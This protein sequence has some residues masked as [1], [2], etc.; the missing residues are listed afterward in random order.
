MIIIRE[1]ETTEHVINPLAI[2]DEKIVMEMIKTRHTGYFF[3]G[4]F[5]LEIHDTGYTIGETLMNNCDT[6]GSA[7]VSVRFRATSMKFIP[8]EIIPCVRI[9]SIKHGFLIANALDNL[10][11]IIITPDDFT[12]SLKEGQF[13]S[14]RIRKAEETYHAK[15]ITLYCQFY[16]P[17]VDRIS[18]FRVLD[19]NVRDVRRKDQPK[20]PSKSSAEINVA[21]KESNNII[22]QIKGADYDKIN[23]E[24]FKKFERI[25]HANATD[26]LGYKPITIDGLVKIDKDTII[27]SSNK[28]NHLY[29]AMLLPQGAK[30]PDNVRVDELQHAD[31]IGL[32]LQEHYDQRNLIIQS[33]KVYEGD[34]F[35]KH[36]NIW[37]I[38]NQ[39]ASD[40]LRS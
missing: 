38:Y 37:M 35:D 4:Y 18:Y 2:C 17:K 13:V 39:L 14:V 10:A 22:S 34:E 5:I 20:G 21:I 32:L 24:L 27:C 1:F 15:K 25:Y 9:N 31:L 8:S 23:P 36:A 16:Q 11:T 7:S 33:C 3:E 40:A 28:T 26:P 29:P 19:N 12:G 6:N 30:L